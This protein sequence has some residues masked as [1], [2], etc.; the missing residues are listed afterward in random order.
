[1][2]SEIP[3]DLEWLDPWLKDDSDD[4]LVRELQRE[5]PPDH[6]LHGIPVKAVARRRD[7]D[8]VLYVTADSS[9]PLA[10]VHLTYRSSR[11]TDPHW[12]STVLFDSWQ[13]WI[14]GCLIPDHEDWFQLFDRNTTLQDLEQCDWGEPTFCSQLAVTIHRLRR[15][16]LHEF[17]VEDLRTMIAQGIGLPFLVPL[18]LERLEA[19]PLAKGDLFA[20]DLL[21][22]VVGAGDRFWMHHPTCFERIYN[23]RCRLTEMYLSLDMGDRLTVDG[24]G[25][26]FEKLLGE[27]PVRMANYKPKGPTR[28]MKD[29]LVGNR[30]QLEQLWIA[31]YTPVWMAAH[32]PADLDEEEQVLWMVWVTCPEWDSIL[33]YSITE[34]EPDSKLLW[35]TLAQAMAYPVRPCTTPCRPLAVQVQKD[36]NRGSVT[37]H[38]NEKWSALKPHLEQTGV[39]FQLVDDAFGLVDG[40][41][42]LMN[43]V[44]L[45][46]EKSHGGIN[47]PNSESP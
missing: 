22:A 15:K 11:E 6:V 27:K 37:P 5:I 38:F 42:E 32:P 29:W 23:V 25:E 26:E 31:G 17:T 39:D 1:M 14:D 41:P 12:P 33:A 7:R 40:L 45:D 10:W 2:F 4:G 8:D 30:P 9:K 46:W 28:V 47:P 21:R 13:D 18:A 20:G 16:P 19:A 44:Y 36:K 43:R 34:L 35:D 24:I 3:P